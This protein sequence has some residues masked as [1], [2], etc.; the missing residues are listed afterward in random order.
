V[1]HDLG[2][3]KDTARGENIFLK[4][5]LR[6]VVFF[7]TYPLVDRWWPSE[8]RIRRYEKLGDYSIERY[9]Q[10]FYVHWQ[11]RVYNVSILWS[12]LV[13]LTEFGER[14]EC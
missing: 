5:G 7:D 10:K 13:V 3:P 14:G 6:T 9:G 4:R 8:R 1:G 12:C 11:G 2:V